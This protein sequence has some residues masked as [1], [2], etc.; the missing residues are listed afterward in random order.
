MTSCAEAQFYL[1]QC[2]LESIDGNRDG[3]PCEQLCGT[4]SR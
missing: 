2:R 3:E 4:S 1:M